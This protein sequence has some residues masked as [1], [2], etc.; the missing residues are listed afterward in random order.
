[1]ARNIESQLYWT[2]NYD[3][4]ID[5]VL[6]TDDEVV[7][8]TDLNGKAN[9]ELIL[10]QATAAKHTAPAAEY[11]ID[12]YTF[13][14][15]AKGYMGAAGEWA[16]VIQYG[17]KV[18][19]AMTLLEYSNLTNPSFY[20]WTSTQIGNAWVWA[21]KWSTSENNYVF[22]KTLKNDSTNKAV[23]PFTPLAF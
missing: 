13:P 8:R 20:F 9:T 21:V 7:A 15:G 19:E 2:F 23:C 3:Y 6:T 10:Q 4:T 1:M 14:K 17:D 5:G 16:A 12:T 11:C 18:K 22:Q